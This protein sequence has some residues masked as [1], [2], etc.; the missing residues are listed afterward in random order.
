MLNLSNIANVVT[1]SASRVGLI[2]AKYA[3]DIL[4]GMGI[5]GVVASS[6]LVYKA[7][8]KLDSVLC[9]HNAEL[10][11]LHDGKEMLDGDALLKN[12]PSAYSDSDYRKDLAIAYTQRAMDVAKLYAPAVLVGAF[13]ISCLLG[14]RYI[15]S[16]RNAALTAAYKLL[17]EGYKNYRQRVVKKFGP[18]KESEL[19]ADGR[20]TITYKTTDENGNEVEKKVKMMSPKFGSQYARWFD[21]NSPQF[22]KNFD[23]NLFFL[24]SAQ[25]YANDKLKA[26]GHVFLNEV[27]DMLGIPRSTAGA[28]VGWVLRGNGDDFIDFGMYN[29]ENEPGRDVINGY[30]RAFLLDFNVDGIIYDLI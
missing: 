10:K 6:V 5:T 15:F 26:H 11:R 14:S 1:K 13:S 25:N 19:W 29:A 8:K 23:Y 2:T 7:T 9:E 30:S 21:E 22:Q 24:K 16:K 20:E 12:A 18:E 3:P 27:Y 28:I 4:M 17:D